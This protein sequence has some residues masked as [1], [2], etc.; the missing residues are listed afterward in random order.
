MQAVV[1]SKH[2]NSVSKELKP[3]SQKNLNVKGAY[4]ET[5]KM[6]FAVAI[7]LILLGTG[8]AARFLRPVGS[9][10]PRVPVSRE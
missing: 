2:P 8:S 5:E 10:E 4:A 3:K 6:Q 7:V 1:F 9:A